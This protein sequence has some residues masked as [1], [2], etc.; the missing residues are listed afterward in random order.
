MSAAVNAARARSC[1]ARLSTLGSRRLFEAFFVIPCGSIMDAHSILGD[2]LALQLADAAP[3]GFVVVDVDGKIVWINRA[4]EVI[5]GWSR[6]EL[7]GSPVERLLPERFAAAHLGHRQRFAAAPSV[8]PMGLGLSLVGRRRDGSE[9]PLEISLGPMQTSH[10]PLALATVR[11]ITDRQRT[12]EALRLSEDRLR[13]AHRVAR[14][15]SWDW[16]LREGTVLRAPELYEL[17]GVQPGPEHERPLALAAYIPV[18]ERERVLQTIQEAI[19]ARRCYKLEHRIVRPDGEERIFLQQ[20]E[21]ILADG[22]AVRYIG[23]TLDI[24]DLRRAER[25]R[26]AAYAE[27]QAVLEQCPVGITRAWGAHGEKLQANRQARVM[28]GDPFDQDA[29]LSQFA[30]T[31]FDFEGRPVDFEA[32]PLMRAL[33]GERTQQVE[34]EFRRSD[35]GRLPIEV[36]AAPI[37]DGAGQVTGA[38]AAWQDITAVK[39]LERLR[40]EWSSVVAHDL[41]QPLNS[42]GMWAQLMERQVEKSPE[43]LRRYIAEIRSMVARLSRMTHDLLDLGRLDASRLTIEKQPVDVV[44]CVRATVERFMLEAG[45]QRFEVV[46]DGEIPTVLGDRDRLSQ[47]MEN[48]LSNAVKYSQPGSPIR[49]EIAC[50]NERVI[51]QVIN[52]G[53]GLDPQQLQ[54][55]FQRFQRAGIAAHK[56]IP[57]IGL[58]LQITRGLIEAHGGQI[59]AECGPDNL[60]TFRF[61]LPSSRAASAQLACGA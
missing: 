55:L 24:T 12:Q 49:V 15:G 25:E 10:G 36:N 53:A 40:V 33:R 37:L 39:E 9:F 41:R 2:P 45:E 14:L 29:G 3:D 6:A 4:A 59:T 13:R 43:A 7:V 48:L 22:E 44:A 18:D 56:A 42:I 27:L 50:A 23:T 58:G 26:E 51:V 60:T 8:R 35:G 61:W 34:L 1:L 21:A 17:Y 54:A 32:M 38:V 52:H 20:G 30:G 11:D 31:L 57:G 47:V 5:F 28:L 16:D 46:I 19:Q